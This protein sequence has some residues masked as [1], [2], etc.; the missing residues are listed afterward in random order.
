MVLQVVNRNPDVFAEVSDEDED[1]DE[2]DWDEF[3]NEM[4]SGFNDWAEFDTE[5]TIDFDQ[6]DVFGRDTV[7]IKQPKHVKL[8]HFNKIT[9]FKV[10]VTLNLF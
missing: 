5:M 1:E 6:Y 10:I 2:F 8:L 9:P 7:S 4:T 3:E